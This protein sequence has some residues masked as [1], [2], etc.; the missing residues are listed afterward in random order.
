[1]ATST[2]RGTAGPKALV[3]GL[4]TAQVLLALAFGAA[5]GMK[6]MMASADIAKAMPGAPEALIRFI[7]VSEVAGSLGMLLPALTRVLPVLTAWAGVGLA[8]IMVLASALH[9]SRG[10]WDHLPVTLGLFA[11]AAFVA[12]GRFKAA[13]IAPR[14]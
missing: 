1:M 9:A 7:G 2:V 11:L 13:P 14:A 4:W 5:G 3:V 10:E 8:T 12:W 6:L